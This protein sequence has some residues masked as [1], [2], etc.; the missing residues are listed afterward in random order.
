MGTETETS[1]RSYMV[2]YVLHFHTHLQTWE[3][4][5]NILIALP[6]SFTAFRWHYLKDMLLTFLK[7]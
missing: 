4:R 2:L 3:S 5:A 7:L 1:F 6:L